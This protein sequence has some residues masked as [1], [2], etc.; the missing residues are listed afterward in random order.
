MSRTGPWESWYDN[1]TYTNAD[2]E[3]VRAYE[4][5]QDMTITVMEVQGDGVPDNPFHVVAETCKDR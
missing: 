3:E 4:D 5:G 2:G 1:R